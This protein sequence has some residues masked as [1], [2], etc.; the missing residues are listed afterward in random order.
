MVI[1]Y[2]VCVSACNASN[3]TDRRMLGVANTL[4]LCSAMFQTLSDVNVALLQIEVCRDGE[5]GFD[6]EFLWTQ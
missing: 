4:R 5:A 3:V 1:P 2:G 6:H